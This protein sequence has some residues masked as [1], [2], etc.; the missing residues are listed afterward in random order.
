MAKVIKYGDE[1]QESLVAGINAVADIV[2]TTIGP[3]GRNVLIRNRIDVPIVTNDGVTIANTIELKDNIEDAGAALVK[4]AARKTNI[5]SG[6]GTTTTTILAQEMIKEGFKEIKNG[7]NAV[8][9]QKEMLR[10]GDQVSEYLLE[11]AIK[12]DTGKDIQR[13][14]AIS[15]NDDIIGGIISA[16]FEKAGTFGSVIVEESKTGKD[17]LITVEGMKYP[18]GSISPYFLADKSKEISKVDDVTVLVCKDKIDN[19]VELIPILDLCAR[20]GRRLLIICEDM[21]T[22]PM[23]M[24][25]MN[26]ARGAINVSVIRLPGFGELKTELTDDLCIA[27]GARAICRDDGIFMREFEPTW[28]GEASEIQVGNDDTVIKFKDM[29]SMGINLKA[30]REDR[31]EE[32]RRR[33]GDL[34]QHESKERWQ[35]RISNLIG[36]ISSV[37]VGGNSEVEQKDKKLRIEDAIQSVSAALEEGIVAGGG[38][39]FIDAA[40]NFRQ[41]EDDA[42]STLVKKCLLSITKQIASNAGKDGEEVVTKVIETNLGYNALTDTYEDLIKSGVINAVKVDRYAVL[43]AVSLAATVITMGGLVIEENEKDQNILQLQAPN[44]MQPLM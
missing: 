17:G 16:A 27:T 31:A 42:G 39:S 34:P 23:N 40:R 14:A 8:Q 2:K 5:I 32:I 22:E 35:R 29:S 10:A 11:N 38:F 20:E 4:S 9:L 3:K 19:V 44:G 33:I 30:A 28:F 21:E 6:D 12:M 24:L 36:G 37:Q 1:A 13:I 25:I 7:I 41:E 18:Y 43:N 15:S 26:K